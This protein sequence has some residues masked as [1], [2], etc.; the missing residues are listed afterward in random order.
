MGDVVSTAMRRRR[1]LVI[2]AAGV[3]TG[4]GIAPTTVSPAAAPP[5]STAPA[6]AYSV[7]TTTTT[8]PSPTVHSRPP[9]ERANVYPPQPAGVPFPGAEW[10]TGELPAAVDRGAVDAA[11]EA[12]FGAPDADARV[13]SIV[14]V[15]GGRIVY[16]RYHPLDGPDVV[17]PSFSVAKSFTSALIGLLVSDG[18]LALDDH[19]DIRQWRDPGDPR[20][21]ITVRD[22]LQMSSGLEWDE[23]YEA[24]SDPV[25][26]LGARNAARF[27]ASKPL[28]S[29]PGTVFE[30]STGTTAILSG[31][32]AQALGGCAEQLD[33]LHRRLLD[34]IGITTDEL[35]LDP[36]GCWYGGLG[37]DM[38]TRDFA[39]FGLLYLRGGQ[40][41]GEQII[42]TSW[43]DQSRSP[44]STNGQYGL[45]WWLNPNGRSFQAEGLF[46]QRIVVVPGL[47]LV[48]A[49]N[50][51][52][53]GDPYTM[54]EAV[55]PL[56][57]RRSPPAATGT[58]EVTLPPTR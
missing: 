32:A 50:S 9:A 56:F 11:V 24:G 17:Y 45:Q 46:G 16:E 47:D 48:I 15:H 49:S 57:A 8:A 52:A 6:G 22:L 35:L 33:Y 1:P 19:P 39:R 42:P 29:E 25:V 20:Q 21:D 14:I 13:Q 30:Y 58:A 53:G 5:P 40:W 18:A 23:V 51:T 12:A 37:A 28:E 55:L 10:P 7:P 44:A 54:I 43:V 26:M 2:L 36:T 31:I 41:D 27:A 3:L 38:T 34:P 4:C